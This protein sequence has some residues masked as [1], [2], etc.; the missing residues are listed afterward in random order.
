MEIIKGLHSGEVRALWVIGSNPAASL[1]HTR[2]VEEGLSKAEFLVV[3]DIFHPT[4]TTM[5][6][7]V[8]L[9]GS[10][11]GEKTGTFISSERRVEL[12]EKLVEPPGQVKDDTEIICLVARAMG[13][14]K[15]FPYTSPEEIF[16][17]WKRITRGRICDMSGVSYERLRNK[18]GPQLPCPDINH[19]G[20]PRL[21]TDLRF[22]RPDGRAALIGRSY[23]EPS[24]VVDDEY[25]IVLNTGRVS[26][27][28]NT[29]T[30]T[31]RIPRL[32][33]IEPDNF[34][35][36]HPTDAARYGISDGDEVEVTS[37]RG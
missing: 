28:F 21:F 9:P 31:G 12:M 5:L 26:C 11:W 1:P 10:M 18:V 23:K 4:E 7:D 25:P 22:P 15:E 17:E 24:E 2:W 14:T 19:P 36:I 29:R 35:E 30:R 20:T 8:I 33:N 32:N 6:A 13:F 37:R 27:H 16:E 34:V 3:Q